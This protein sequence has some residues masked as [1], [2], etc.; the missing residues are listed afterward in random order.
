MFENLGAMGSGNFAE[1]QQQ[2]QREIMS[3]PQ[4]CIV[5]I[6]LNFDVHGITPKACN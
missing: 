1:M 5:V 3:N 2:V 6:K 4:V